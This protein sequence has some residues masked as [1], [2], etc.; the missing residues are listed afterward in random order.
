[1]EIISCILHPEAQGFIDSSA[2]FAVKVNVRSERAA[3]EAL[4]LRGFEEFS[5]VFTRARRYKDRV[6]LVEQAVF[7]GYV[8]CR[9]TLNQK[10][11]VLS[12]TAVKYLVSFG[13]LPAAIPEEE[14]SA[15]RAVVNAGGWP[16]PFLATGDRV[17]VTGGP[18]AGVGG[19]IIRRGKSH[20]FVVSISLLQRSVALKI[21]ERYLSA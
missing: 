3:A 6:K 4:R 17:T 21:D 19:M 13:G 15:V 7:P 12:A 1:M 11:A 16:L 5:P 14:I 8:F 2:W 20:E 9:C 10:R 18:L